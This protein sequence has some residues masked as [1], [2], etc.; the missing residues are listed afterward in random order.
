MPILPQKR[1][2]VQPVGGRV[3][4]LR[5]PPGRINLLYGPKPVFHISHGVAGEQLLR[6]R[7]VTVIDGANRFSPHA[8]AMIARR[9]RVDPEEM[10]SRI[11]VSRA[12]TCYQME[13]AVTDRAPAFLEHHDCSLLIVFG[14]LDLFYDE[15]A[16]MRDV[17]RG[18]RHMLD[19]LDLLK[20]RGIA[21]LVTSQRIPAPRGRGHLFSSLKTKAD[22]VYRLDMGERYFALRI[23]KTEAF[24]S[25]QSLKDTKK[26]KY[27]SLVSSGLRGSQ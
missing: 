4:K 19:T 17:H 10:L 27:I 1:T 16:P 21:V 13:S 6:N 11:S 20:Q 18:L 8:I 7:R 3:D 12:F 24:I 23:E 25:P 14:P 26:E 2:N 5:C 15:Q 9:N 22:I